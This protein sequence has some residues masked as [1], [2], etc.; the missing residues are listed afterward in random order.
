VTV[1]IARLNSAAAFDTRD[2]PANTVRGSLLSTSL[3]YAP[4]VLG[5]DIRF[6]RLLVQAYHFRPWRGL[7]LASAARAGVAA[8]LEGQELIPSERFFAGGART[9]RGV[10]EDSLGP[11]HVL[12]QPAGGRA[13]VVLNQEVRFPL[14][15]WFGG[16]A[17]V[18]AGNVFESPSA[19]DVGRL[20]GAVG[21]G[22]RLATPYA[23]FRVDY[24]VP[25]SPGPTGRT[26]RWSFGIG[27]A[28]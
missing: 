15:R 19:M 17:F 13:L 16:V 5:S 22:V 9:V 18:D 27:Q 6:V 7:G 2:N 8:A 11:R 28:F 10:A 21:L 14:Y 23:L 3:D 20:V 26:G 4:D 25:W 24:G 12:G 1:N